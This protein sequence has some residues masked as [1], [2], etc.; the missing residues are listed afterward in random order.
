MRGQKVTFHVFV[1]SFV[2]S[3]VAYVP[4][5]VAIFALVY[6]LSHFAGS[7]V[8]QHKGTVLAAGRQSSRGRGAGWKNGGSRCRVRTKVPAAPVVFS[9]SRG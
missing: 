3:S 6:R 4:S 2:P 9:F 7:S 5:S 1:Y 8:C